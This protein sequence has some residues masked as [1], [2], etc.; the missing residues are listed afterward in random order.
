MLS[1]GSTFGITATIIQEKKTGGDSIKKP[2]SSSLHP[3]HV[4]VHQIQDLDWMGL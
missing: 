1:R 3:Q 2:R 4:E